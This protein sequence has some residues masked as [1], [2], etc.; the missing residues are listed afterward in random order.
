MTKRVIKLEERYIYPPFSV[1]DARQG[2]WQDRKR[3]W[4]ALGIRS[5]IGRGENCLGSGAHSVYTGESE[6]AGERGGNKNYARC[7]GQDIM[8]GEYVV[9]SSK[10]KAN[11]DG[12]QDGGLLID[13]Y[14]RSEES[15]AFKSQSKLSAIQKK[16]K[17]GQ[18]TIASLYRPDDPSAYGNEQSQTGTSVFDPVLC[19]LMYKWFCPKDGLVLDP[20]AGGSVR[21]IV[22]EK[23]GRR[24]VGIDLR[25]EQIEANE[26]QRLD[27][28]G[29][30]EFPRWIVGDSRNLND[31]TNDNFDFV[32]TCPP[33]FDLEIY[34]EDKR[35]LS[36][37]GTYADFIKDFSA[38][39]KLSCAKLKDNRFACVVVGDIRDK[40]G[41][42]RGFVADTVNLFKD[43]GLCLYN[44]A[45]LIT[46]VGSLPVRTRKMFD[47]SRKMGK[48]HQNV[49]IFVKG[50]PAK[51]C[52]AIG[53]VNEVDEREWEQAERIELF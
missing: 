11:P 40:K 39:I 35:D 29:D 33:Y 17:M 37:I 7:F 53:K 19:E 44:D 51:A 45:I 36:N 41:Y 34:S 48:T 2:V 8:R 13:G 30:V 46:A 4:L 3:Q 43:A 49:L 38:I 18:P 52:D 47:S 28:L 1:L 12:A 27:I 9:G 25:P 5:E 42:Y 10:A 21:G 24:Y 31:L 23:C 22:A 20:F 16:T 26:A 50:D 14:R 6:W 32:F 15:K